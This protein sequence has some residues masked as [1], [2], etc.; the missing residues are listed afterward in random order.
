MASAVPMLAYQ[1]QKVNV[2]DYEKK[3]DLEKQWY[4]GIKT[5]V[6]E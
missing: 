2:L 6:T 3:T 5:V 4:Q 1:Q